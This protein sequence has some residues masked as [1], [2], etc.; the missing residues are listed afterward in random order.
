MQDESGNGPE[1]DIIWT[2]LQAPLPSPEAVINIGMSDAWG[3]WEQ[4]GIFTY[5]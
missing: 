4:Q 3:L 5:W 1:Y 2:P